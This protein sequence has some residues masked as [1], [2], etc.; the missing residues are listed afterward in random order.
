METS[1]K[2]KTNIHFEIQEIKEVLWEV[3]N[4][5]LGDKKNLDIEK[6]FFPYF[7]KL[8]TL[9]ENH[10]SQET[11]KKLKDYGCLSACA[12]FSSILGAILIYTLMPAKIVSSDMIKTLYYG[13][14]LRAK[15][16]HMT[17]EE[18]KK[19]LTQ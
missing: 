15:L 1:E 11:K 5:I 16:V 14:I 3:S 12:L 2:E 18:K 13:Q 6:T 17:D 7:Q 8:E 19:W 4:K 9:L 10:K